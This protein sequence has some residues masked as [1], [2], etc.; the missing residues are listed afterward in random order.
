MPP[1]RT[2]SAGVRECVCVAVRADV[3]VPNTVYR[4][5]VISLLK[6]IVVMDSILLRL[7]AD[8]SDLRSRLLHT[9]ILLL[10]GCLTGLLL[11]LLMGCLTGILL[12]PTVDQIVRLLH[13]ATA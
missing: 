7:S 8:P 12:L 11:L 1:D 13:T 5:H 3:L 6:Y 9:R 4:A 2:P 10:M